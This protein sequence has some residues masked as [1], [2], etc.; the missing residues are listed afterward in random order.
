MALSNDEQS[1]V[2]A[3]ALFDSG[4]IDNIE[5]GTFKGLQQIHTYLFEGLLPAAGKI[6]SVNI[7]KGFFRF[8]SALY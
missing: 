6:R 7:A 1:K 5:V 4:T 8:A 3:Y 2:R